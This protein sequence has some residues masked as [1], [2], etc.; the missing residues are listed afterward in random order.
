MS[1]EY[2]QYLAQHTANVEKSFHWIVQNTPE[3]IMTMPAFMEVSDQICVNH[4]LSKM[5]IGEYAAYDAYFYGKNRSHQVVLDFKKAWLHHIHLNSHHWQH[6]V[7]V[8]D[9]PKEGIVA[10]EM[11]FNY[12]LEMVCDWWAFSW[13][14]GDLHT[15]FK[16]WD[17]HKEYMR[18]HANTRSTVV[19][20]LRVIETKL[21]EI[22]A[23]ENV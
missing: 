6:W 20:I 17:E 16:W 13:A 10:L 15:I 8:N 3:L 19:H 14:K 23:N 2:D 12:I 21:K 4:D 7:L 22:E 5:G 18:L 9:E 1:Y 11:P